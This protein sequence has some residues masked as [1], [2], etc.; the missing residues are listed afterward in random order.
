MNSK[1]DLE[2]TWQTLFRLFILGLLGYLFFKAHQALEVL[3]VSVIISLGLDPII[4]FFEKRKLGR[5]FGSV[6]VFLGGA[7]IISG[8]LYL[9]VPILVD[10]LMGFLDSFNKTLFLIFGV[11]LP[12]SL[13]ESL[14]A[15]L[16]QIL[17]FLNAN[18]VPVTAAVSKVFQQIVFILATIM[19]SFYLSL[20]RFGVERL[21]RTI[22]PDVYERPALTIFA[23]FKIKIRKWFVAQFA[24]SVL[25]GGVVSVGLWLLGVRFPIILGLL[26]AV[27]ELVPVIGPILAGTAAFLVG[28]SESFALGLYAAIFFIVIQQL[29]NHIFIPFIIGRTMRVHPVI[30]I[31]SMLAGAY[32]AGIVGIMLAVPSAV[33]SQEIFNYLEERKK[34]RGGL[35]I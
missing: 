7:L 19:T 22:L 35:G 14:S 8:V 31:I 26:A 28:V 6:I 32:I 34:E 21:L 9:V 10:E 20:D 12:S 18:K 33:M 15:N 29:E 3:L 25:V 16:N 17:S 30:V 27:F 5:L 4:G 24:L 13:I 2:I 23:K 1:N 11:R